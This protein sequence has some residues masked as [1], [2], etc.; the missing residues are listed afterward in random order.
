MDTES[1]AVTVVGIRA[2]LDLLMC[3]VAGVDLDMET[4]TGTDTEVG[5]RDRRRDNSRCENCNDT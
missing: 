5:N 4:G 3:A 1:E 2:A